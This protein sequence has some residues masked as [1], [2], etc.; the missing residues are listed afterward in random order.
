MANSVV[1]LRAQLV[2]ALCLPV[3]VL[4]GYLLAE[5]TDFTSMAVVLLVIGVL[6]IPLLMY[7]YHPLLI[8]VWNAAIVPIF[9][10]GQPYLWMLVAFMGLGFATINRF[11]SRA[12]SFIAVPSVTRPLL[13]LLLV[14]LATSYIRGGLGMRMFG[15]S[16]YGG[17]GYFYIIASIAGFFAFI[18]QRIPKN[19]ARLFASLFFISGLTAL[20][21]NL[22]YIGG[23]RF[24]FLY[25]LFPVNYA[26]EQAMG[27]YSFLDTSIYRVAGLTLGSPALYGWLLVRYGLRGVFDTSKPVRLVL[28]VLAV[29]GSLFCGY[30]GIVLLMFVTIVVQFFAEE[31]PKLRV[32][33]VL[34]L[35]SMF[36]AVIL[37]PNV[38]KLPLA[39]QRSISFL[40]LSFDPA[41]QTSAT[42]SSEWRIQIWRDI[43]PEVPKYLLKGKGYN[44]DPM[45]LDLAN[46]SRQADNYSWAIVSGAYHSG[47]LTLVIPFGIWGVGAFLW[48]VFASLKYLYRQYRY[49]D[50]DLREINTFL[51]AAFIGRVI[52]YL[53][54]FGN[55]YSDLFL[56]T[57]IIG[58]S[59]SINGEGLTFTERTQKQ[60]EPSVGEGELSPSPVG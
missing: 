60:Q 9:L 19:R 6:S 24:D 34:G 5:P 51:L 40:P 18:S 1:G 12:A 25:Y 48:F 41:V 15:S 23:H 21:S 57:G 42:G 31:I 52:Y 26:I 3:A 20:V 16:Q 22:A 39:F 8:A 30:R 29:L 7:S 49:G 37:V 36:F 32:L 53:L 56:F 11:T 33:L 27:E 38:T 50:P 4:L 28:F 10:P 54:I 44:V 58:L 2:F 47:P 13:A 55:F 45:E 46:S 59:V 43:L 14:V 35:C 17:R